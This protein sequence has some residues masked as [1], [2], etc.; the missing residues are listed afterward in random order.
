MGRSRI[1]LDPRACWRVWTRR[2]GGILPTPGGSPV[3]RKCAGR[4]DRRRTAAVPGGGLGTEDGA[5]D[6]RSARCVLPR[7]TGTPRLGGAPRAGVGDVRMGSLGHIT[8][9]TEGS[10][11]ARRGARTVGRRF[12]CGGTAPG[13]LPML[14]GGEAGNFPPLPCAL[15]WCR[16]ALGRCR[17]RRAFA[18]PPGGAWDTGALRVSSGALDHVHVPTGA[19]SALHMGWRRC[20][21]IGGGTPGHAGPPPLLDRSASTVDGDY[22]GGMGSPTLSGSSPAWNN[23]SQAGGAAELSSPFRDVGLPSA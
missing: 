8:A 12:R 11:R 15:L 6:C 16:G 14:E 10:G 23:H 2:T 13:H 9:L 3:R 4:V 1:T 7:D 21:R 18:P 20:I 19:L 17:L 5:P 22:V